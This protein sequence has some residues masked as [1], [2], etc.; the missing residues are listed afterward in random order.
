MF[1][2]FRNLP[3]CSAQ[4]P[5]SS[6]KRV[7]E[8]EE[9]EVASDPTYEQWLNSTGKQF[10]DPHRP[11]NWIGGHVPFPLNPSFKPHPPVSD[12]MRSALYEQYMNDPATNSVRALSEKYSMSIARVDAIL[13][14]KGL[15]DH[16]RK[17][18]AVFNKQIQ[19]GF[20]AGMET[21]LGVSRTVKVAL[22]AEEELGEDA[23]L[24]D[25]QNEVPGNDA[26]RVRYQRMFWEPVVEGQEPV[27]TD[28]LEKSRQYAAAKNKGKAT[29]TDS[30][31]LAEHPD[32]VH[33]YQ[34]QGRP[35]VKFVDVGD[36]WVDEKD[37]I[38]RQKES[39]RKA[40]RKQANP[41]LKEND[42]SLNAQ[43]A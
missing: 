38:R 42:A 21:A 34:R 2:H 26:A 5:L 10:K 35:V 39:A 19:T 40:R 4:Q 36:K 6:L 3:S 8:D 18:N 13:R 33:I 15:E 20:L 41:L 28:A 11:R 30:A 32:R 25:A 27:V 43:S 23:I 29:A 31:S 1:A 12:N 22:R 9:E 37:I 17:V 7:V 24:A 14:L 16:W